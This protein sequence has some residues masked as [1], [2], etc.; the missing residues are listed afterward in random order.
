MIHVSANGPA[1]TIE[2]NLMQTKGAQIADDTS[3]MRVRNFP[4]RPFAEMK[5]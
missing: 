5:T 2:Y 3:S 4:V 1:I